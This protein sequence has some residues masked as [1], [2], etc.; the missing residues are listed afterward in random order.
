[1]R[2][3]LPSVEEALEEETV[4]TTCNITRAAERGTILVAEDAEG[5]REF[6]TD[7][8]SRYGYE[9]RCFADTPQALANI[10]DSVDLLL[11]DIILPS[12][13]G[14]DLAAQAEEKLPGL[15]V[16]YMTGYAEDTIALAGRL[17]AGVRL[18]RKPFSVQ[19]LLDAIRA[20]LA[21]APPAPAAPAANQN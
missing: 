13:S 21:A 8:L 5:V 10:D 3:Y 1:M 15:P 9:V 2:I 19:D 7:A 17:E 16:L 4:N 12:G 11:T 20:T 6:V 18:L 14:I